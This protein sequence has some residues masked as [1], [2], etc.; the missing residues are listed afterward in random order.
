MRI[1]E[2]D[3]YFLIWSNPVVLKVFNL[4]V[5]TIRKHMVLMTLETET[6][7]TGSTIVMK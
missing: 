7:L 6:L 3:S 1:S 5:T 2:P 4:W